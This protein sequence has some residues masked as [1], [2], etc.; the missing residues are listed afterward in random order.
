LAVAPEIV[1]MSDALQFIGVFV[2]FSIA[3]VAFRGL[4]QTRSPALLR[5]TTAFTFLG[6]GF[7]VQALVGL[8]GV[9]PIIPALTTTM[10]AGLAVA[11]ALMETAGY[12][13]LAFSHALDVMFS[14]RLG[15]ALLVFPIVTMS[16]AQT[17][18]AL[19]ILSFYFILYGVLE[20]AY[21]YSRTRKPDTL[22]IAAGL[23]LLGVGTLVAWFSLLYPAVY[24][25]SLVQIII[26]EI[27]LMI[28]F[29]PVL[30]YALGGARTNGP[31]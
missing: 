13:F 5:L 16:A 22:L 12:F 31:I 11:G 1:M 6:F 28:L 8:D 2:S 20:T 17:T 10:I 24:L 27:G 26:K 7:M 15:V 23:A 21:A 30:S 9:I 25:L 3:Y 29:I 19:S 18:D 14:R 4:K